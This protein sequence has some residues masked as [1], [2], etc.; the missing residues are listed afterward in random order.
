MAENRT[1]LAKIIREVQQKVLEL[2]I[3]IADGNAG[4]KGNQRLDGLL[5]DVARLQS[6]YKGR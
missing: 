3:D 2:A 1:K 6:A 5:D 4:E